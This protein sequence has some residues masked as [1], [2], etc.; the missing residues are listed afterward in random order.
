ME[1]L[2]ARY[3]LDSTVVFNEIMYQP[4]TDEPLEFIELYNQMGVDMDISAWRLGSAV[5]FRFSEGT[6]IPTGGYVVI[7][8]DP[9]ALKQATGID[10]LG[11]FTGR[12]ANGGEEIE[13]RD[14]NS[15]LMDH[16][17]YGDTSPWPDEAD[18]WGASLAKRDRNTNSQAATHWVS[19]V[20]V[21]GTPG[22]ANFSDQLNAPPEDRVQTLVDFA[23]PWQWNAAGQDL[24]S[25]WRQPDP[26][27]D[28]GQ[29]AAGVFYAGEARLADAELEPISG[30][31]ATAS[32]A[33]SGHEASQ[34]VDGSGLGPDGGHVTTNPFDTMWLSTGAVFGANQDVNPEIT[35]DL[36][37][38]RSI[39][40]MRVW[41]YNH[42]DTA[43]CCLNRGVRLADIL[44]AG[45]DG[46][47]VTQI[48]DQAFSQAPGDASSFAQQVD[49][50]VAAR[51]VKIDV[52]TTN[53][54]AN[55]GDPFQFVGLSEVQFLAYPPAGDVELPTGPN[56]YY[57]RHEFDFDDAPE[58]TTLELTTLL[59]DGAVIYLN[60]QEVYRQNM[61]AGPVGYD[62]TP[63]FAVS[64]AS[65]SDNDYLADRRLAARS[66]C[67]GG[68][69]PSG[70]SR[71]RPTRTWC[72]H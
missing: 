43:S 68:G 63:A 29:T 54:V 46:N 25:D 10:A 26:A 15:R 31:T 51:Y 37:A 58:R 32:S 4:A 57:F 30:V 21:G 36:G 44:V 60:G 27:N 64:D 62:S 39:R 61:T 19:S 65:P 52:D 18:G 11:P 66:K 14:R 71:R 55:H 20:Q 28:F 38:E 49:L 3:V 34:V 12:L 42:V 67:V 6:V 40:A 23:S 56:T 59:D 9:V 48:D 5:D 41:N 16:V 35:F 17:G 7:A 24:G 2:E 72:S 47:F 1:S 70:T 8:Q 53:G 33:L 50:D 22:T 45:D 13:L 69:S